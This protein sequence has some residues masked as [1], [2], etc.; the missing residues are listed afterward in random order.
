MRSTPMLLVL[1][2]LPAAVRAQTAVHAPGGTLQGVVLDAATGQP[3]RQALV[4]LAEGD[5]RV[6]TSERGR[7]TLAGVAPGAARLSIQQIGY[8]A[9]AIP[10]RV[11]TRPRNTAGAAELVVRLERQALVLPEVSVEAR[12]C[13]GLGEV[14]AT[15]PEGGTILDETFKNAE[16][17][18]TIERK[19]PFVLRYQRFVTRF[20]SSYRRIDGQV[21][22]LEK[23][24]R[25]YL[26][27][28]AGNLVER[29]VGRERVAAFTS[30]DIASEEFQRTH[31]FW[32]AGRDSAEGMPGYRVDFAPR[33]GVKSMDWAGSLIVDSASMILMLARTRLVNIPDK[34]TGF[35]SATCAMYYQPI[36]PSLPQ[37]YQVRCVS[38]WKR[39]R[40]FKEER[41][42]LLDRR[43][44]KKPP[45]QPDLPQ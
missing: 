26:P 29:W 12:S 2:A 21:D 10:L 34:G 35:L 40:H 44:L 3:V 30:S 17:I 36:F 4:V 14:G 39:P 45:L 27:Y 33:P 18:L 28:R 6:F 9:Q 11:D 42:L 43:F 15:V 38:S 24:S 41:L 16:R 5:Q 37:E 7:F 8:R 32:Y 23:D 25:K 20:D 22:T 13:L 1:L 31:C 19:Y